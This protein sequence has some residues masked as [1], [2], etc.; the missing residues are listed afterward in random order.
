MK[1]ARI[2]R[3]TKDKSIVIELEDGKLYDDIV[4]WIIP[5]ADYETNIDLMDWEETGIRVDSA[6][7][8]IY[9]VLLKKV[10]A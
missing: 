3:R 5:R 2:F 8:S 1:N 4:S 9:F 10:K 7:L 6:E